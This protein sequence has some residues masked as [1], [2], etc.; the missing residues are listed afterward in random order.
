MLELIHEFSK[1][2]GYK[3]NVQKYVAFLYANNE[4]AEREIKQSILF[5]IVKGSL[6]NGERYLQMISDKECPK[7]I[8]NIIKLNTQ[9]TN[10]PVKK[11]A[12]DMNRHF[13]KEDIRWP[14][15][16]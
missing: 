5:S 15:G 1:V 16:T 6:W 11:W 10:D 14:T 8:K 12:E 4:V 7:S 13:S 2:I 9:K 3:I